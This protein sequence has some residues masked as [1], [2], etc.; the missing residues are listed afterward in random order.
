[1]FT[2][3][4]IF[5]LLRDCADFVDGTG[6]VN[7]RDR[8]ERRIAFPV[9]PEWSILCSRRIVREMFWVRE[10]VIEKDGRREGIKTSSFN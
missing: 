3:V 6:D 5:E 8:L 10:A 9:Q 4:L 2:A 7:P 1:M